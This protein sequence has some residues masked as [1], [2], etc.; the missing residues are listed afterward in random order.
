MS[1]GAFQVIIAPFNTM[2][3][4]VKVRCPN[5]LQLR[6]CGAFSIIDTRSDEQKDSEDKKISDA[7]LADTIDK[8]EKIL[9]VTLVSPTYADIIN[10]V[11]GQDTWYQDTKEALAVIE[12]RLYNK[13]EQIDPGERQILV[14]RLRTLKMQCGFMLPADFTAFIVSWALGIDRSDIKKVTNSI[15]LEAAILATRGHDN[16]CNHLHGNF[17]EYH[18]NEINKEAW[19]LYNEFEK[20]KRLEKKGTEEI[21]GG[22]TR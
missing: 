18:K 5:E 21:R 1:D 22:A 12:T 4:P 6:A 17:N 15:L 2:E 13:D 11:Y 20:N 7:I 9:E 19:V 16:P 3:V 14:A 10:N 8:Q